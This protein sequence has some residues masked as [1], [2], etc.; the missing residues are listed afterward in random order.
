MRS[1]LPELVGVVGRGISRGGDR[2]VQ[3]GRG[4][5]IMLFELFFLGRFVGLHQSWGKTL[6]LTHLGFSLV[7][8]LQS[9][10]RHRP[11]QLLWSACVREE[12]FSV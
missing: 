12:T 4:A 2:D 11:G 10:S 5:E 8:E 7:R 9:W 3:R 6:S 1:A